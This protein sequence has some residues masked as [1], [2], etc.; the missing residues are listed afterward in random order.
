MLLPGQESKARATPE[1]YPRTDLTSIT[2]ADYKVTKN[3]VG[4]LEIL[5][6]P[7]AYTGV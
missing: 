1:R 5:R 2:A 6:C 7:T 3:G 4:P